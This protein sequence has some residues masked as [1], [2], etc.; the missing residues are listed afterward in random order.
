MPFTFK[1]FMLRISA[2]LIFTLAILIYV[3]PVGGK[4]DLA[5]IQPWMDQ[6]GQFIE[7]NNW[8]LVHLNHQIFK[9]VLIAV[10]LSF[11]GLWCASFKIERLQPKRW[12]YGY[13]FCV[14]MLSTLFIGALKS[15]STHACPWNM[16]K[17]TDTGFLWNFTTTQ[18]HCFPGGHAST[19]FAL[20]TGFFV[21]RLVQPRRAWFYLFAG[22]IL[23][24]M[25][26]WGQ[27]MRGAHFLSHNLWTAWIILGLNT[28]LYAFFYPHFKHKRSQTRLFQK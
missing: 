20:L 23:G 8:S 11:L 10:Y 9:N 18:G 17:A 12:L 27:M 19:G 21:F 3:F 25:M 24:F 26:G 15:Q 13:M 28:I 7:R 14:S 22:L 5:L 6:H 4:I 2:I 16:T 1:K